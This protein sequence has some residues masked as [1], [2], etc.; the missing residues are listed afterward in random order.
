MLQGLLE[1][2]SSHRTCWLPILS[3]RRLPWSLALSWC[4]PHLWAEPKLQ[5]GPV[6]IAGVC[7][8]DSVSEKAEPV[9]HL[10]EDPPSAGRPL[11][12]LSRVRLV[13]F[14]HSPGGGVCGPLSFFRQVRLGEQPASYRDDGGQLEGRT[15]G[16]WKAFVLLEQREASPFACVVV[17]GVLPYGGPRSHPPASCHSGDGWLCCGHST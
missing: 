6:A 9:A 5:V 16:F 17:F 13:C 7:P 15:V 3:L 12:S 4:H 10:Q 11:G 8:Q 14:Q 1:E 2:E